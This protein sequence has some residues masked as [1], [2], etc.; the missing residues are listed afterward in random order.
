M[1]WYRINCQDNL[2]YLK[3]SCISKGSYSSLSV[4]YSF[5]YMRLYMQYHILGLLYIYIS[6]ILFIIDVHASCFQ[7]GKVLNNDVLEK[8]EK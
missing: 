8:R 1:K 2:L 5:Y 3:V 7:F 4:L 6:C